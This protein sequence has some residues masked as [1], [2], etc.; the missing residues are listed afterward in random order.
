MLF[1]RGMS[2]QETHESSRTP[3][4]YASLTVNGRSAV[5]CHWA[6]PAFREILNNHTLHD[7][8]AAQIPH[9]QFT[10]RGVSYGVY[11]P[12]AGISESRIKVVI[13]RNRHGGLL[14]GI[15]GEYFAAPSRAP[16]ELDIYQRLTAANINTPEVVGYA[17]YPVFPGLVRADVVTR[18]LPEG[19]DFPDRWKSADRKCRDKMLE[20]LARLLK[21]L[22]TANIR[23]GDLNLKNIYIADSGHNLTP[24]LLDID[25]VT[26]PEQVNVAQLNFN[27]LARSVRKW[28]DKWGLDIQET[29]LE[30]LAALTKE[31]F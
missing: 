24:Y 5:A 10:G 19:G 29:D 1:L 23:H 7:W 12:T 6:I 16:L 15:T 9:E 26:F 31:I 4:G 22:S 14:G 18:R 11:L 25:R 20:A 8:A 3:M 28:R 27:R 2:D 17:L 13:R 21:E 30:R